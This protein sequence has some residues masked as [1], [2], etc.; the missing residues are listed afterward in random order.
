MTW[1]RSNLIRWMRIERPGFNGADWRQC[2]AA[3][4]EL[5][6][7]A[8]PAYRVYAIPAPIQLGSCSGSMRAARRTR[9]GQRRWLERAER[10]SRRRKAE[11]RRW[12]VA[13][14]G[15][16][17]KGACGVSHLHAELRVTQARQG[18]GGA[19]KHER[20]PSSSFSNNGS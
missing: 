20:R 14:G 10:S 8:S 5:G 19:A 13:S 18:G 4:G 11:R 3:G 15:A 17:R 6:G 12:R 16:E 9:L 7:G 1:I 2:K